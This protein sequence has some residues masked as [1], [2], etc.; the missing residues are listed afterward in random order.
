[1]TTTTTVPTETKATR[2]T[3][4]SC[5]C[6]GK[7]F[8][9]ARQ[10]AQ[11]SGERWV[12]LRV[13][14]I[15]RN[16]LNISRYGCFNKRIGQWSQPQTPCNGVTFSW[17]YLQ[18]LSL[19]K[20]INC[21]KPENPPR[22]QHSTFGS[23]CEVCSCVFTWCVGGVRIAANESNRV[24]FI[25]A[26]VSLCYKTVEQKWGSFLKTCGLLF[27]LRESLKKKQAKS[28]INVLSKNNN[29]RNMEAINQQWNVDKIHMRSTNRSTTPT[30]HGGLLKKKKKIPELPI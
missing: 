6:N 24:I 4:L 8:L 26:E 10:Q 23:Q 20:V 25:S 19:Q 29:E 9:G 18:K 13:W 21:V 11:K 30:L 17:V 12:Y 7:F 15:F 3:I 2:Q 27:F 5:K 22:T 28:K 14:P 16:T 1:M